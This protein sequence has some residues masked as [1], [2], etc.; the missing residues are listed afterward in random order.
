MGVAYALEN[1]RRLS[2]VV[3]EVFAAQQLRAL[4]GFVDLWADLLQRLTHDGGVGVALLTPG[5]EDPELVWPCVLLAREL[6]CELVEGGDLT[7]RGERLFLK[8]LSGLQPIRVL[9]RTIPGRQV[10]PLELEPGGTG[11]PGLLA[12][13]RGTVRI[14]NDP[15]TGFA[16]A[17]A[18]AAF[19]PD[20]ARGLLGEE[21]HLQSVDTVWLGDDTRHADVLREPDAWALRPAFDVGT[22][23]AAMA[24]IERQARVAAAPWRFVATAR[25]EPSSAPCLG[26]E[27]LEPQPVRVRAC[28]W[29]RTA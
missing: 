10:D 14:V 25:V 18:L 13:V 26:A 12:A 11:V 24:D 1:R 9:L 22:A 20:L 19:L 28:S 5:H 2:R 6:S 4:D 3:P 15:G 8:T 7:V 27:A 23:P 16:E 29:C 21:L 17:P